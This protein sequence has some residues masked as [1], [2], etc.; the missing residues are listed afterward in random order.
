VPGQHTA[1]HKIIIIKKGVLKK[2]KNAYIRCLQFHF[3]CNIYTKPVDSPSGLKFV[4]VAYCY[5]INTVAFDGNLL[6]R[7]LKADAINSYIMSNL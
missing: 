3:P 7:Q 4:H 5:A 2:S 1:S 6:I